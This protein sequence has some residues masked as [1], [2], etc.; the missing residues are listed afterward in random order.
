MH[1]ASDS[2]QYASSLSR[3]N[4]W[5]TL[6]VVLGIALLVRSAAMAAQFASLQEDPDSYRRLAITW[7]QTG[8][9]GFETNRTGNGPVRPTAYRPPLY[10][11]VLAAL[12]RGD[13]LPSISVAVLHVLLG[14]ATP[15][16]TFALGIRAG[17]GRW[18]FAAAALTAFDPILL[19]QS[20][21]VMTET[22]AAFLAVVGLLALTRLSGCP[23]VGGAALAGAVLG[24]AVLC[25][26]TYFF[27]LALIAAAGIVAPPSPVKRSHVAVVV[28]AAAA[29][30]APWT[31]RNYVLLGRPIFATTHGGYTLWLANNDWYYD[32]LGERG[33]V[34][35]AER[36]LPRLKEIRAGHEEDEVLNDRLLNREA[37]E[38]I[39]RRPADFLY[40]SMARVGS[41]WRL[42]PLRIT[43]SES[44]LRTS[45]RW[46]VGVWYAGV[47]LL[48]A[49]GAI[50]LWRRLGQ[51]PWLWA[52]LLCASFTA[53]HAVYW[54]DMRMRA[55]LMPAVSLAA[56]AGAAWIVRR[57]S[58]GGARV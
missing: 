30:L 44:M 56:A 58:P 15:A 36:L 24:I 43:A 37:V 11:L 47:F 21:V 39:R 57:R 6:A 12:V 17:L 23:T 18:S 49:L 8:V 53:V 13:E 14:A 10:P 35:D 25:R 27:W 51:A 5:G 52:I 55:P 38:T 40:A 29:V 41:L 16:I 34:F 54:T 1:H 2:D 33:E 9:F 4:F 28:L 20:A 50:T 31:V 22:L 46:V 45:A 3:D 26:P 32:Q 7:R 42:T 48:A 19:N